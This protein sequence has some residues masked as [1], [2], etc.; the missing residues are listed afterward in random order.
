MS[1]NGKYIKNWC[2]LINFIFF[3]VVNIVK[4]I[5]FIYLDFN[6]IIFTM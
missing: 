6:N 2:I 5:F 1:K 3:I 4:F